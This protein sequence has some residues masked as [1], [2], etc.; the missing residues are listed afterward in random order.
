MFLLEFICKIKSDFI[1]Y[2]NFQSFHPN[3][4]GVIKKYTYFRC[5]CY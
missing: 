5:N 3:E 4:K 1:C 2:Y